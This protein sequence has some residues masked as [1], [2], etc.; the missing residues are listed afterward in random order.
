L[1]KSYTNPQTAAPAL[2]VDRIKAIVADLNADDWK[3][4]DA[5]EKQLLA[6]GPGAVGTL[7]SLRDA[8]PPEAQQR[9][10]SVLKRLDKQGNKNQ[11]LPAGEDEGGAKTNVP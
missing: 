9:I 6:I 10:D 8:Q 2:M 4:R 1:L 5:A 7:K 11:G 3:Q